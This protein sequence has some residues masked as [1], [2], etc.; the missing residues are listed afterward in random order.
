[1][2]GNRSKQSTARFIFLAIFCSQ[3]IGCVYPLRQDVTNNPKF[4][5]GYVKGQIYIIQKPVLLCKTSGNN[6]SGKE[7]CLQM[8]GGSS[9]LPA[10]TEEYFSNRMRWPNVCGVVETRTRISILKIE[11]E[12]NFE[13]G[14]EFY[15]EAVILDGVFAGRIANVTPISGFVEKGKYPLL[16]IMNSQ[17]M[18]LETSTN[19]TR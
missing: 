15:I 9:D 10:M 2:N 11:R 7:L 6:T 3:I 4:E 12:D 8:F 17:F 14:W 18:E 5:A 16:P 1:M 13:F 19:L